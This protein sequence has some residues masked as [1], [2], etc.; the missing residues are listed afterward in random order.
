MDYAQTIDYLFGLQKHGIKLG[1]ETI[2]RVLSLAHDPHRAF[3]SIHIA[4]TNG[5]GSTAAMAASIL[6]QVGLKTGL[7]TSPH[8]VAFNE[9]IKVDGTEITNQEVVTLTEEFLALLTTAYGGAD[10]RPP[11]TFFEFTTA[12]AFLHFAKKK[13]DWAVIET[14][15]GGRLDAT[16]VLVPELSIITAISMEHA[17]FLGETLAEIAG[18][19]AGI[20]KPN[21]PVISAR[22]ETEALTA[23]EQKAGEQQ[24]SLYIQGRHFAASTKSRSAAGVVFDFD[25]YITCKDLFTPLAG[26]YQAENAALAVEATSR[27]VGKHTQGLETCIR[28]GL[29]SVT[30]SGRLEQV[31]T[32]PDIMLD[33]AHN[34][35]A[36]S[37]LAI[38]LRED[39]LGTPSR[40]LVL[41]MGTM[42]DKD[43]EGIMGP[44]LHLASEVI[45]TRPAYSR[46]ATS[47][48]LKQ[49]AAALGYE[50]KTSGSVAEALDMAKKAANRL[51]LKHKNG[52]KGA[53]PLIVVTGSFYV[54]GEAR[55]ILV[56]GAKPWI[57]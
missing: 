16:N 13:V 15:M 44:L 4:G 29:S 9:R 2:G 54:I 27:A 42:W 51:T 57:A 37:A 55:G 18:E 6:Q 52:K 53:A 46:A 3:R 34:P 41:V 38:A 49:K 7:Y 22:Q 31:S 39:F 45:F 36:A 24:S 23:M 48:G 56:E 11:P 33:A 35:R 26:E 28:Q 19:K 17:E 30:L 12:M 47:T 14:G 10:R 21:V 20:I 43:S 50:A 5:K 32:G 1:L 8:L 25:G 40:G